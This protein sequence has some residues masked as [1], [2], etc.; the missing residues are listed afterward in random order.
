MDVMRKR[1]Q[2]RHMMQDYD[3]AMEDYTRAIEIRPTDFEAW[4]YRSLIY[5]LRED[6]EQTIVGMTRALELAP[7]TWEQ[8]ETVERQLRMTRKFRDQEKGP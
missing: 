8:R 4:Y 1:A 6:Y 2:L 3:G 7:P 5:G